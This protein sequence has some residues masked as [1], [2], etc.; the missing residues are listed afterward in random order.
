DLEIR[1]RALPAANL[2]D[3]ERG[4]TQLRADLQA[5][6]VR[7]VGVVVVDGELSRR[8]GGER[9]LGSRVPGPGAAQLEGWLL[10]LGLGLRPRAAPGATAARVAVVHRRP[11]HDD[12]ID[13]VH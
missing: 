4:V 11:L 9:R 5:R 2:A 7:R 3:A 8:F 1:A 6:A 10:P 12:G 13:V